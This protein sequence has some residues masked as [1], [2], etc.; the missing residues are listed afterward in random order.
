MDPVSLFR[1]P[2]CPLFAQGPGVRLETERALLCKCVIAG[3]GASL[4]VAWYAVCQVCDCWTR[5]RSHVTGEWK[6]GAQEVLVVT[7]HS[8]ILQKPFSL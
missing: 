8:S 1:S 4:S 5:S 6:S 3:H 2:T 7:A